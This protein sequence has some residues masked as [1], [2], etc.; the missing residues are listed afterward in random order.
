MMDDDDR[1]RDWMVRMTS[2]FQG[3]RNLLCA[4][5][6]AHNFETWYF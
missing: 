2:P 1:Q 3:L 5:G 6:F 4:H